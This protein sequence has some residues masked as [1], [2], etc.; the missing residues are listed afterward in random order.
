[1]LP[2]SDEVDCFGSLISVV[3]YKLKNAGFPPVGLVVGC[4]C[5]A[6]LQWPWRIEVEAR[7]I[8]P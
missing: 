8:G 4:A 6:V 5:G 3:D 2:N 7:E 1:M